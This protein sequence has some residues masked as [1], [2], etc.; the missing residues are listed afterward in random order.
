MSSGREED[1]RRSERNSTCCMTGG[2][3]VR[4][5]VAGVDWSARWVVAERWLLLRSK[6]GGVAYMPMSLTTAGQ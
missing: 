6:K 5:F 1:K 3:L 4:Y 2:E